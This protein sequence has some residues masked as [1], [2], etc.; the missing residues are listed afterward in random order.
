M[1]KTIFRALGSRR[2]SSPPRRAGRGRGGAQVS[3][4]SFD[5]LIAKLDA[6]RSQLK[7]SRPGKR[8]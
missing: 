6:A 8:R 5:G 7:S 2:F 4:G 3:F 1:T